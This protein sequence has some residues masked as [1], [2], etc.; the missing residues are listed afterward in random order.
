MYKGVPRSNTAGTQ[1]QIAARGGRNGSQA[2]LWVYTHTYIV[3][4][5]IEHLQTKIFWA[6][7]ICTKECLAAI[8]QVLDAKLPREEDAT[9]PGSS[10]ADWAA[11]RV[12]QLFEIELQTTTRCKEAAS[13]VGWSMYI[14]IHVYVYIYMYMYLYMYV[15][16]Y[17]YIYMTTYFTYNFFKPFLNFS[18]KIDFYDTCV[19]YITYIT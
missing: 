10:P 16:T 18:V 3:H 15:Y 1:R 19:T 8:L 6:R 4:T 13:E 5:Y 12:R 17:V 11:G 9:A 14:Y 2:H 7:Y